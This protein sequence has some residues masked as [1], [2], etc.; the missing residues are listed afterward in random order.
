MTQ[1]IYYETP[2]VNDAFAQR[3]KWTSSS[4][5]QPRAYAF[6]SPLIWIAT[7]AQVNQ[8]MSYVR[9]L[10]VGPS[11]C[12]TAVTFPE[13]S[14][15]SRNP[16]SKYIIAIAVS[17]T[18]TQFWLEHKL[19]TISCSHMNST[20]KSD[21]QVLCMNLLGKNHELRILLTISEIRDDLCVSKWNCS[22]SNRSR[23]VNTNRKIS[24]MI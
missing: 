10:F 2:T 14:I 7:I 13:F 4:A 8:G 21:I 3:H 15:A 16:C 20:N 12:V 23:F 17:Y 9:S 22:L 11:N 1:G 19:V 24:Q 6:P 5:C 18:V